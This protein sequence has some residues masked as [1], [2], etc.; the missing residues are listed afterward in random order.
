MKTYTG[1]ICKG[2]I[3][4]NSACGRCEKCFDEIQGLIDNN[5]L[6]MQVSPESKATDWISIHK[7]LPEHGQKIIGKSET[8]EWKE[9]W[10]SSEPVGK[11]THWKPV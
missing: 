4:L 11:M 1:A 7:R 6:T 10:D 2:S 5:T 9:I 8:G 3:W